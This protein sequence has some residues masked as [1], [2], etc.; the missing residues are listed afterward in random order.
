MKISIILFSLLFVQTQVFS[1][2]FCDSWSYEIDFD[3]STCLERVHIDDVIDTNNIWE[4]GTPQKLLFNSA[5]T[6]SKV[7]ITDSVNPYPL[8]DTSVFVIKHAVTEWGGY[9]NGSHAASLMGHYQVDTDSLN[10]FGLIEY[11]PDNGATWIDLINDTTYVANYDWGSPKPILTGNSNGWQWIYVNVAPLG[12]IFTISSGDTVQYR[13]TFISDSI[14]DSKD[15]LM[16]DSFSF[17]DWVE[18]INENHILYQSKAFPNPSSGQVN[19]QTSFPASINTVNLAIRNQQN[20]LV[21]VR[22]SL[23]LPMTSIDL[24]N[25]ANGM[26]FYEIINSN[27]GVGTTGKLVISN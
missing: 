3:D 24:S 5:H 18:E 2:W 9:M 20:K 12:Q 19:F 25:L 27:K 1:Q 14:T 23:S 11:S 26:Y 17:E 4:I 22:K 16:F 13:F 7:I 6:P 15:G 10:D 21:Y 8:N